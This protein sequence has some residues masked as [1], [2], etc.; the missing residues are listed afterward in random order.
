MLFFIYLSL[1]V[2]CWHCLHGMRSRIYVTSQCPPSVCPSVFP[3]IGPQQQINRERKCAENYDTVNLFL[4]NCHHHFGSSNRNNFRV[5]FDEIASIYFIWKIYLY[6]SIESVKFSIKCIA[7]G[8]LLWT[9]QPGVFGR[10]LHGRCTTGK[11]GQHHFISVRTKLKRDL[12]IGCV[13][14]RC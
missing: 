14:S 10:L 6:F 9:R 4:W 7:A 5:L 1:T 13:Q 12:S 2:C 3:G 11:C 8:L